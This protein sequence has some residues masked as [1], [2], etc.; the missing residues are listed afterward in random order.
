MSLLKSRFIELFGNPIKNDK[1]WDSV[2][3]NDICDGIGDGLHGTPKYDSEGTIPFINGNNLSD[4]KITI[5]EATKFVN[6]ETYQKHYIKI[7][8]NAILLSI[9]GTLGKLAFFNGEKVMLG[10][11]ACFLN[12]KD[13]I[14]RKFAYE[15]FSSEYF[16]EYL[17]EN[18]SQSTILNVGLKAI[19]NFRMILPS[20]NLQN[21]YTL[22]TEQ[23]DKSKFLLQ[24]IL[25]KLELLK[26]S[27]FIEMFDQ[28]NKEELIGNVVSICRGASPRPISEFIT[29]DSEGINWI[30]IGDV[31]ED[32]L[33]ITSAEEKITKEGASKSRLVHKGDF[34]LSNS[35]SFG[36]PYILKIDGCVHDGWL[37]LSKFSESFNEIFLY[38]ALKSDYV[39]NQFR[40]KVNGA[41][42]K[43][44]NSDLVKNTKIKV[45][46]IEKQIK[47]SNFI[48]QIDK[49]KF[50]E[51]YF[52]NIKI[53]PVELRTALT[54]FLN[55][56]FFQYQ[57][58]AQVKVIVVLHH[59]C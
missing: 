39:Q 29:K 13:S 8:K 3:L 6:E 53:L 50:S 40:M 9:N 17:F 28:C 18:S 22:F 46:P 24:Q 35:M 59:I 45:P 19:R 55:L 33:Y 37:I 30:K 32:S 44:L 36:R 26:K 12:L 16:K 5:Y 20:A 34:I 38:Y 42:V 52:H 43:N 14:N 2:P 47:F 10:K 21:K 15:I 23:I 54:K 48:E 4:G 25:E 31:S 7:S 49:S 1:K 41:T 58:S 27:R 51:D 11:S 56:M 57:S